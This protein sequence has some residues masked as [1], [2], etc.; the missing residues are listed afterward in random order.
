MVGTYV[1]ELRAHCY[2]MVGSMQDA[3]DAMQDALL[4]AWTGI[5]RFEGRSSL[6]SWLYTIATNSCLRLIA[7]R[8]RRLLSS[9]YGPPRSADA[10]LGEPV[11]GPVWL[12]PW[13]ESE[14]STAWADTPSLERESLEL[15][16]VA[17]L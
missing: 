2:R 9:D 17:A 5:R 16:F 1:R 7:E 8:P 4:G 6:R 13:A 3:D 11:L 10:D 14:A 12:E 15:S